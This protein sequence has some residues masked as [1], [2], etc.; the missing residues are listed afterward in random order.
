MNTSA[1]MNEDQLKMIV[2]MHRVF[3]FPGSKMRDLQELMLNIPLHKTQNTNIPSQC[4]IT[5]KWRQPN[6]DQNKTG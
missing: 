4:T 6:F 5:E 3:P 2:V 1:F